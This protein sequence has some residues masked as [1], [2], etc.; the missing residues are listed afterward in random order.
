MLSSNLCGIV[1]QHDD[2]DRI[3]HLSNF[4]LVVK[5]TTQF[6]ILGV[7]PSGKVCKRDKANHERIL[8]RPKICNHEIIGEGKIFSS[9]RISFDYLCEL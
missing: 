7:Q 2:L 8:S 6:W 1:A 4:A 3:E 5:S 9:L